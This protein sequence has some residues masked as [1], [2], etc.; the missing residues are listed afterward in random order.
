MA[1]QLTQDDLLAVID[2]ALPDTYLDPIKVIGPGYELPQAFAKVGE[3]VSLGVKRFEDDVYILTSKGGVL[4]TVPATFYRPSFTAGA[5]VMLAGT[6]IRASRGG[7][8]FRTS[9]DA[10][11]GATDLET[12]PVTAIAVGYGYEWNI[13]GPFIDPQGTTWP[14]EL[15]TIDLPLQ[16]PVFWDDTIQVRNDAPADGLGRPRTLDALGAERR[17]PRQTGETDSNYRNRIRTLPDTVS[18]AA[19]K[20]QLTNYFRRIPGLF[21]RHIETWA[22][23]YQE[24]YD[25]P[26]LP[27][28]ATENYNANLFCYDDPRPPSPIANRYLGESDYL[29]AF[30]VEVAM[31]PPIHEFSFAYDDPAGDEVGPPSSRSTRSLSAYDLPDSMLPPAIAPALDGADYA[32]ARF[33][34]DLYALLDEIKAGGIF[35]VIHIQET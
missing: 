13:Q 27:P 17:L 5:G 20:R 35:V 24:C 2:R 30:I 4:A 31:P 3:R 22:H 16:N 7:Q 21:W 12:A 10:T 25:A 33:F 28:T 14:G 6:T 34:T 23:E 9:A 26:D 32:V 19:I 11:F 15:D 8:V 29:G 18:P 1:D